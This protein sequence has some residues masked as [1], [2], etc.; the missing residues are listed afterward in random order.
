MRTNRTAIPCLFAAVA[1]CW[2]IHT[3]AEA[4]VIGRVSNIVPSTIRVSPGGDH[5]LVVSVNPQTKKRQVNVDGKTLAG[6]YDAIAGG[7][8]FFSEDGKHHVFVG[9]RG[10]Q[11]M[12]VVDGVE[13]TPYTITK[14]G[15]PIAGLIFGSDGTKTHLA[16]QASKDGR[17]YVVGNGKVLGP[18]DSVIDID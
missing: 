14:E 6:V 18:Y 5:V 12:V 13:Q 4:E 15:W 16:Y 17:H 10:E 7:T 11:C 8:P 2:P 3:P 9:T 1:L